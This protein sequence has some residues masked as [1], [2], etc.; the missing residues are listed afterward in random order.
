MRCPPLLL[1]LVALLLAV[2]AGALGASSRGSVAYGSA[3]SLAELARAHDLRVVRVIPSLQVAE[4]AGAARSLRA[5]GAT[6][7]RARTTRSEPSLEPDPAAAIPGADYEWQYGTTR[8]DAVPAWVL[9]AAVSVPVAVIDTGADLSAPDLA[10]KK[11]LAFSVAANDADVTDLNGH[12]TFVASIA[13]GASDNG[14]GLAGFAGDAPLLVVQAGSASG[15]FSDLDEAAAIVYAVDHGARVLNL[16][17]GGTRTSDVERRAVEYAVS[18]GA[19]LVAAAGNEHDAGNPVEYPAALLQPVDSGGAGGA[20]LAVGGSDALGMR[21][22]FSNSGSWLSLVAP[23]VHVFGAVAQTSSALRYV[24]VPLPGARLGLYGFE[25]GTSFA[26]P[27][28]AGAAAL[29]WAANPTLTAQQVAETLERSATGH[30]QWNEDLG[31]GVLDAASAVDAATTALPA[32]LGVSW[33]GVR[34]A[35]RV[36]RAQLSTSTAASLSGRTLLLD[37]LHRGG[38][39]RT[40]RDAPPR[41]ERRH[42]LEGEARRALPRPLRR[43]A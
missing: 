16:S 27:Q 30:G 19:L 40:D 21:A 1:A 5:V 22:W 37:R 28:V 25:S 10:A 17:L 6:P 7:L 12:G 35:G 32:G 3:S 15:T 9:R 41:R 33:I 43:R 38:H 24:R 8:M 31:F 20:G 14:D 34:S 11:P 42:A 39:W 2:P 29:V 18:R 26:A 4:V 36:L 13:A 23:A